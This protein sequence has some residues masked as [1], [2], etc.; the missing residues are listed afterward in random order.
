MGW[1]ST[2]DPYANVGDAALGFDSEEAAKSFA[3]RHGWEYVV[4]INSFF[5]LNI[6]KLKQVFW[7][8]FLSIMVLCGPVILFF[9]LIMELCSIMLLNDFTSRLSSGCFFCFFLSISNQNCLKL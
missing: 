1:T 4:S 3:E 6:Y 9:F 5:P 7:D 2:G 8:A